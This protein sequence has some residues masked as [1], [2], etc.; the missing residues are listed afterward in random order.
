[1]TRRSVFAHALSITRHAAFLTR[2]GLLTVLVL[3]WAQYSPHRDTYEMVE[4]QGTLEP[5][6]VHPGRPEN[7]DFIILF[8]LPLAAL[9]VVYACCRTFRP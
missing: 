6:L 9:V 3:L 5:M 7:K 4:F 2:H 8:A 1:M